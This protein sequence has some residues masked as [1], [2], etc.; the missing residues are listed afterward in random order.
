[1]VLIFLQ[2]F[3]WAAGDVSLAAYI[4]ASLARLESS[5]TNV[6]ALGA[7]MAFLYC[8]YIVTYAIT[9]P[10]L[11]R[12]IDHISNRNEQDIHAAMLNVGGVQFTLIFVLVMTATFVPKGAFSFNPKMLSDEDLDSDVE[13]T[14]IVDFEFDR[15]VKDS[16]RTVRSTLTDERAE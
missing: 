2:S 3:G 16:E 8:T 15:V 4:Q 14:E 7:V 9:S 6:S 11:G 13:V 1:M 5:T 12:Y 10:L